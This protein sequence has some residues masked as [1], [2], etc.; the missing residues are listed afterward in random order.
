MLFT[1]A[2]WW[3][4]ASGATS[5]ANGSHDPSRMI[6]SEGRVYIYSTGGGAKSS[7]D[8]LTW[9]DEPAPP[10][11]RGLLPGNQGIWAPDGLYLNGQYYLYGAM[12]TAAKA[13]AVILTTSPT[14]NPTS[15]NYKWTDQG[16]AI[17]GPV[18]VTHSVIDA[19]PVLDADGELWLVW[20]G[21]YPF[22]TTANS[23]FVTRMDNKTGLPL[24]TDPGWNPPDSPGHAI[25]QGHKEGPYIHYHGGA[26]FLFYQTGSCCSGAASTYTIHVARA[27]SITGPYSGDRTFD[28]G[29]TGIHGPGH[30]GIYSACGF[31]RFT[32]HYYPDTGGSV[33]GENE[34]VWDATGWPGVGAQSTTPL[35][36]CG[37][38][39]T[40]GVGGGVGGAAGMAGGPD[41]G[42]GGGAGATGAG[43][44]TGVA[45]AGTDNPTT[46]PPT[47]GSGGSGGMN[48][49][50]GVGGVPGSVG[51]DLRDSPGGCSC[52]VRGSGPPAG[53]ATSLLFLA[54]V[55]RGARRT[56][57]H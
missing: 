26:Y 3:A 42:A 13:S 19:A 10:W 23:I 31:E 52:D 45:D 33:I 22:A 15:P 48:V 4:P 53:L 44:A 8:G 2:A 28:A 55:S 21:G 14:L 30:I 57:R 9:R 18:G 7:S 36:L 37:S 1:I 32:Y 54:L 27:Q 29:G 56:R 34:L 47:G 51:G 40:G 5:G 41:A 50:P 35:R 11:N 38:N 24:T 46:G 25:E 17:S 12:W 39:G 20:G 6:E 16:V 49:M 43:G